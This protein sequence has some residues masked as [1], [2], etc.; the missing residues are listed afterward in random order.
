VKRWRRK[1]DLQNSE[2]DEKD[3]EGDEVF[4]NK[5]HLVEQPI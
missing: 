2:E 3:Q 4:V 1:K 5:V